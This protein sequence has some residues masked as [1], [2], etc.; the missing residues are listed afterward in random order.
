[1][2]LKNKMIANNN[3]KNQK[4]DKDSKQMARNQKMK[5]ITLKESIKKNK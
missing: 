4:K 5:K 1:M 2:R 3:H